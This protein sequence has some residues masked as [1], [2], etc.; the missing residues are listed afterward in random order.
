M[1]GFWVRAPSSAFS[2]RGSPPVRN[3]SSTIW[4]PPF[5]GAVHHVDSKIR[6]VQST[7]AQRGSY[8]WKSPFLCFHLHQAGLTKTESG[9]QSYAENRTAAPNLQPVT[10]GAWE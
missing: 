9:G 6:P 10:K 8:K 5:R 1:F 2:A 3:R 7:H 4:K